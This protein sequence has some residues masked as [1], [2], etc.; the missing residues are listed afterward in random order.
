M[1]IKRNTIFWVIAIIITLVASVYQ[2]K[3]GPTYPKKLTYTQGVSTVTVK[4]P[5]SGG[6]VDEKVS[7]LPSSD[8]EEMSGGQLNFVDAQLHYRHY[9]STDAYTTVEFDHACAMLPVQ[10][11]AGK[12]EYYLT[13]DGNEYFKD[14]PLIIRFKGDVSAST[15]LPHI[16]F[17]F[18]AMLLGAMALLY[19]LVDDKRFMIYTRITA[20]CLLIGGFIFGPLVQKAAFGAYWTGFPFGYDLTDNK[21]LIAMLAVLVALATQRP[22]WRQI[23]RWVTVAAIVVLFA[24]F[25]IPHSLN[26]SEYNR[27][28]GKIETGA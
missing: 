28:S 9:P 8:K 10:P 18:A 4:M 13:I 16:I 12:L 3:T 24:I 20:V 25:C 26:G 14:A 1:K 17:L 23:N 27:D 22:V 11:P 19:A 21:T 7:L 5:R 2:R 15:L 6:I